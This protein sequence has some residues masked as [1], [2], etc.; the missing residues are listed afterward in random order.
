MNK[1]YPISNDTIRLPISTFKRGVTN[2]LFNCDQSVSERKKAAEKVLKYLCEKYKLPMVQLYVLDEPQR[3]LKNGKILGDYS[4]SYKRIRIYN[5][6][7]SLHKVVSIKTFY[8]TLLH[9][10]MHHY[11]IEALNLDKTLHTSGFYQ[12]ISDLKVKLS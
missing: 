5:L 2:D 1:N 12:R 11:D 4:P 8:D 9:E 6:T 7:A 3:K 10:F